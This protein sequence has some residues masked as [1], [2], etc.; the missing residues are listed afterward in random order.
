M[1]Q[2]K[3]QFIQQELNWAEEYLIES[4][5]RELTRQGIGVTDDL[6]RSLAT[7]VKGASASD[8]GQLDLIFNQSG[9]FVDMGAGRGYI[10]GARRAA[11]NARTLR[12][13]KAAKRKPKK[14]YSK[15]AY[16]V[17]SRLAFRLVSNYQSQLIE[18]VKKIEK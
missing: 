1:E 17:I 13:N 15:T 4:L 16:G 3:T 14:W 6:V 18:S 5:K 7:K 12:P 10:K 2:S 8:Q 9:R 11:I